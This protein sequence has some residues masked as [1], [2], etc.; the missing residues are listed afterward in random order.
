MLRFIRDVEL[1]TLES[2]YTVVLQSR[3]HSVFGA[4]LLDTDTSATR[5][6][7]ETRIQERALAPA[8]SVYRF[9]FTEDFR[10]K[11]IRTVRKRRTS[12]SNLNRL[13]EIVFQI[14][15]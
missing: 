2:E 12:R 4:F 11:R 14:C 9:Y 8:C 5:V 3:A 7:N 1:K 13:Q 6:G 10:R 15:H